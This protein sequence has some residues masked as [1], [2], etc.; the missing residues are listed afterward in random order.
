M[1]GTLHA[2]TKG[3]DSL[4]SVLACTGRFIDVLILRYCWQQLLLPPQFPS[5]T[6]DHLEV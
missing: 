6:N 1:R 3:G 5:T 4:R 2:C